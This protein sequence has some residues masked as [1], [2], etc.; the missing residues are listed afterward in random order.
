[1]LAAMMGLLAIMEAA[2][3]LSVQQESQTSDEAFNLFGGYV[4]LTAGNFSIASAHPP[5]AKD[6]GALPLLALQPVVPPMTQAEVS[7][8]R[9]GHIFLYSNRADKVLFAAR[10]AMTVFPLLLAVLV[11]LATW[12]TFNARSAFIALVLIAFEPNILAHGPLVTND[13]ALACCLFAAVYAFWR[14]VTSPTVWRLGVCGI[15]GGLTLASRH[16]GIIIFPILFLLALVELLKTTEAHQ[17]CDSRQDRAEGAADLHESSGAPA[18]TSHGQDV[19]AILPRSR[20][21]LAFHLLLALIAVA[22]ISIAVLWGFYGFRYNP[23]AGAPAPSMAPLLGLL[24]SQRVASAIAVAARAHLLPEA[25]LDGLAFLFA[26]ESRPTYLLGV[27]YVHGV[28]F[29]FSTVMAIK[30]TL[31]FLLLLARA[32]FARSLRGR[33]VRREVVWM[34]IPAAVFLAAS[35]TSNLNIGIRHILPVYPFLI[36]LAA[37]AAWWLATKRRAW[38]IAVA[39]VVVIHAASSLRAFPNYLPYSNELWGGPSE[40]YRVL[41]DSNVDWG[42]NQIGRA[43]CRERV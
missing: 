28:W 26:T 22:A 6:V 29:Y 31:G 33:G 27:R 9:S 24:Q 21:R 17:K 38:A 42:Q 2:M 20:R 23:V 13:V 41:S 14:Y 15:A 32:P 10:A 8:F 11:F 25:F 43:S 1:M 36:V 4:Y 40:T 18:I 16:S 5:L 19:R 12:E 3:L 34:V 35:L 7:D 30:S 37:S 39:G